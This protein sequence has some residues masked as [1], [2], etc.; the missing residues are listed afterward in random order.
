MNRGSSIW[1]IWGTNTGR[2][3]KLGFS[4]FV[5]IDEKTSISVLSSYRTCMVMTQYTRA[6]CRSPQ[7]NSHRRSRVYLLLLFFVSK[8]S[9][10][11]YVII[12]NAIYFHVCLLWL[13]WANLLLVVA[14]GASTKI[15]LHFFI[16][17]YQFGNSFNEIHN[18]SLY[19]F[20]EIHN[21]SLS[22]NYYSS[23]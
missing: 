23:K 18:G 19:S 12:F 6:A 21:G 9:L 22:N 11:V 15:T 16:I 14:S 2:K 10:L 20:N 17:Y 4:S 3:E 8:N 7:N 13:A 1:G 5:F